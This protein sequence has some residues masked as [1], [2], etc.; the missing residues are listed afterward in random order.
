MIEYCIWKQSH[1]VELDAIYNIYKTTFKDYT[2]SEKET[3]EAFCYFCYKNSFKSV[4]D[5]ELRLDGTN[6]SQEEV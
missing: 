6:K 4:F 1:S 5:K 2:D 3:F